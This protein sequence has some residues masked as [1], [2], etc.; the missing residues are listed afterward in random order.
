MVYYRV[1]NGEGAAMYSTAGFE[2]GEETA[3]WS[4]AGVLKTSATMDLL[5]KRH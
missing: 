3:I 1:S 4:T 5:S 2:I